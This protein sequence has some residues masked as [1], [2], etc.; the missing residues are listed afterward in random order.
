MR[1]AIHN[2]E[3]KCIAPL[4]GSLKR[5]EEVGCEHNSGRHMEDDSAVHQDGV[6]WKAL[7][8]SRG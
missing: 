1:L 2:F 4:V 8:Q 5:K 6:D 3:S 7:I